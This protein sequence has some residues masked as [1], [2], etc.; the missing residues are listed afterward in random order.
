MSIEIILTIVLTLIPSLGLG[1]LIV[2]IFNHY[3]G[4]KKE[5]EQRQRENKERQYKELLENVIGFF[6][7]WNDATRK[8]KFLEELYTHA[9]LY[10]SRKVIRSASELV[11]SLDVKGELDLSENGKT[12]QCYKKLVLAIRE[13][14]GIWKNDTL[15]EK[16]IKVFSLE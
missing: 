13:D 16:D 5:V 4:K 9:P 3:S 15:E 12:D 7:G 14:L 2:A 1:G 11:A 6:D 8:K 10:A